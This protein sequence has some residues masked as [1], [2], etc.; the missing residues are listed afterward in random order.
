[1]YRPL[2]IIPYVVKKIRKTDK[3]SKT[4]HSWSLQEPEA[5]GRTLSLQANALELK[6]L[7]SSPCPKLRL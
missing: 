4:T 2:K 1:M 7:Q 6:L 3:E 5:F